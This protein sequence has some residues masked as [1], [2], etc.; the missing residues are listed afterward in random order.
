MPMRS[1]WTSLIPI[2]WKRLWISKKEVEEAFPGY[3]VGFV[4]SLSLSVSCH[5]GDGSL[6]VAATRILNR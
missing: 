2:T 3:Q 4:D 1:I 5:I 6:A